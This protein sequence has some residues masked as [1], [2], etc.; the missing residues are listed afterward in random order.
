MYFHKVNINKVNIKYNNVLFFTLKF[1]IL[2]YLNAVL[3]LYR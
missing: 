3:E 2:L 1:K